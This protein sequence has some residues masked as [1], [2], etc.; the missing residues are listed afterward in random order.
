[1]S[2][3]VY[4]VKKGSTTVYRAS[5]T[6]KGHHISLGTYASEEKA[7]TAYTYARKL[8]DEPVTFEDCIASTDDSL[9]FNYMI[10]LLNYRDNNMYTSSPIYMYKKFFHYYISK[11]EYLIFDID[12]LFFYSSHKIMKRGNHLFIYDYGSQ[13]NILLRYGIRNYAVCG[14]DYIYVNNNPHDLRYSNIHIINR[15]YGVR[16]ENKEGITT[17]KAYIHTAGQTLI[18]SYDSEIKAAIAYNK[19]RDIL[20]LT[21]IPE[22][23][24]E[25]LSAIE[26]A[27]LYNQI[28]VSIRIRSPK[29]KKN[30]NLS[31]A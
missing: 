16:A 31:N 26:Y 13:Q 27:K 8:L 11:K 29:T 22:N 14:R 2:K 15:Y 3:G 19:A 4:E 20:K 21:G 9:P 5:I 17:Y 28:R 6:Y 23:Y 24:I 12:D 18:G 10:S 7:S 1:M 30:K 25:N